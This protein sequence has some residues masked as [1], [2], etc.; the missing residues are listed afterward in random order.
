MHHDDPHSASFV[1]LDELHHK[2]TGLLQFDG[3]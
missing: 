3:D 2:L 1:D